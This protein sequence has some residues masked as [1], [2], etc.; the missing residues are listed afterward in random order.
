VACFEFLGDDGEGTLYHDVGLDF[1]YCLLDLVDGCWKGNVE[2]AIA[3]G[4]Q[5]L[6]CCNSARSRLL[7]QKGFASPELVKGRLTRTI[8]LVLD[9]ILVF[10]FLYYGPN[11]PPRSFRRR[12]DRHQLVWPLWWHIGVAR[13]C[14]SEQCFVQSTG[15][16]CFASALI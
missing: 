1:L 6:P 16:K 10:E 7:G 8:G 4:C 12:V 5:C 9:D 11:Q 2:S 15:T 14:R 3:F 13:N